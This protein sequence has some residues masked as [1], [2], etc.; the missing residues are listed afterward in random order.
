MSLGPKIALPG[1]HLFNIDLYREKQEKI[2]FEA[3]RPRPLIFGMKLHLVDHYQVCS[4]NPSG[5]KNCP[6]P[7]GHMFYI[8][9]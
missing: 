1:G 5:A 6:A 9:L 3:I 7:G 2:L 4:N 8:G